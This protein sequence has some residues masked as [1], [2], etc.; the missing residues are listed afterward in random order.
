MTLELVNRL[1]MAGIAFIKIGYCLYSTQTDAYEIV[2]NTILDMGDIAEVE[3]I[4][5]ERESNQKIDREI[6]YKGYTFIMK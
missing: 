4:V 1:A 6:D 2:N 5:K 3:R